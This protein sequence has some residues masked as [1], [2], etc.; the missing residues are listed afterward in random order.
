M[1]L[2]IF[3]EQTK[4]LLLKKCVTILYCNGSPTLRLI[5][6][7][8]RALRVASPPLSFSGMASARKHPCPPEG[9]RGI[10]RGNW[11]QWR[12]RTCGRGNWGWVAW[13]PGSE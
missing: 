2:R 1:I 5:S 13:R 12:H 3:S 8:G 6:G 9:E 10:G 7:A 4:S 11:L